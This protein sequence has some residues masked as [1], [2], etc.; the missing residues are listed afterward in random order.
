MCVFGT[1]GLAGKRKNHD[2]LSSSGKFRACARMALSLL[3]ASGMPTAQATP[4]WTDPIDRLDEGLPLIAVEGAAGPPASRPIF[5]LAD[6]PETED[7][8]PPVGFMLMMLFVGASA[9]A[10]VFH[11]WVSRIW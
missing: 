5:V 6:A 3:I 4:R 2:N 1:R 8:A 11:A 10:V 7:F 9:A